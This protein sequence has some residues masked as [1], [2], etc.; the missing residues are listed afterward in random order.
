MNFKQKLRTSE[1]GEKCQKRQMPLELLVDI[2]KA[3]TYPNAILDLKTLKQLE[4]VLGYHKNIFGR[5]MNKMQLFGKYW[6]KYI[7][8]LLITSRIIYSIVKKYTTKEKQRYCFIAIKPDTKG[9]KFLQMILDG[10]IDLKKLVRL[11]YINYVLYVMIIYIL[12][13]KKV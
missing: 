11:L 9:L 1:I 7:K 10:K 8:N 2:I 6:K 4:T 5:P 12:L 13:E 3:A